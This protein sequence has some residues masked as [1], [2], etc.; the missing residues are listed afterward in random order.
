MLQLD[1]LS[2]NKYVLQNAGFGQ[3]VYIAGFRSLV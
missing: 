2:R 1:P 3:E